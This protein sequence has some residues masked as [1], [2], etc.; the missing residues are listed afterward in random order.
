MELIAAMRHCLCLF[1][2]DC[3]IVLCFDLSKTKHSQ[4]T[5]HFQT[6]VGFRKTA[7]TKIVC[8][9]RSFKCRRHTFPLPQSFPHFCIPLVLL[10]SLSLRDTANFHSSAQK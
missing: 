4:I 3:S 2:N 7:K 1:G 5:T 10:S 8:T 9:H 6:S